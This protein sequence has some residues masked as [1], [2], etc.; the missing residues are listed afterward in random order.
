M[1]LPCLLYRYDRELNLNDIAGFHIAFELIHPF[2]DGNG[3]VGRL[4]MTYQAIKNNYIPPLILNDNRLDYLE[5][6]GDKDK[7]E[8]FL[9]SSIQNSIDLVR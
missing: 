8:M 4:L 1:Q 2:A 3:R 5:S 7:L 9:D 6:L